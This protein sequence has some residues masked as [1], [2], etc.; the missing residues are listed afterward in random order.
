MVLLPDALGPHRVTY[1]PYSINLYR[2]ALLLF[3]TSTIKVVSLSFSV[4]APLTLNRFCSLETGV[5]LSTKE[6]P[7]SESSFTNLKQDLLVSGLMIGVKD[8]SRGTFAQQ[9]K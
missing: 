6:L 1:E 2:L 7:P 9:Y 3:S 5:L 8:R 4:I